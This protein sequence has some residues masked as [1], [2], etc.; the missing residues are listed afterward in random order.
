MGGRNVQRL[1]GEA[2][3][4]GDKFDVA[5]GDTLAIKPEID[6]QGSL[7]VGDGTN[8]FDMKVFLGTTSDFALFD[9]GEK[10]LTLE[11][12]AQK[13][14]KIN[15]LTANTALN[16]THFD[17]VI[18]N[19]GA[20]GAIVVTIPDASAS[21]AGSYFEYR[22]IANQNATFQPETANTLVALNTATANSFA[23]STANQKIGAAG[24]FISDGT[25]WICTALQGTATVS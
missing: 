3:T 21:N 2:L 22:G 5:S 11:G 10:T 15:A 19:R 13:Q 8:D 23:F 7:T 9:V 24:H 20:A 1:L 25:A 17:G 14:Q 6:D 16:S 4:S 18:T 12:S